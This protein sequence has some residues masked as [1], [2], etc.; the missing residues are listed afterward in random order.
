MQLAATEAF[1]GDVG[2]NLDRVV[3]YVNEYSKSAMSSQRSVQID[4]DQKKV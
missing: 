4:V 1:N 2:E 3:R